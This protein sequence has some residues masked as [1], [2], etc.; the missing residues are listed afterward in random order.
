MS[1]NPFTFGN[2]IMESS[3]FFGR[4]REIRQIVNRLL[5]SAH[6]S[7]SIIGEG[8]MGSTS[9]LLHLHN[10][11][12]AKDLGLTADSF[13]L[14]YVDFQGT[15]L[16]PARFWKRVLHA[17]SRSLANPH[18][19]EMTQQLASRAEIDQFDLEDHFQSLKESDLTTVLLMDEFENI[20]KNPNFPAGFFGGLRALAIHSGLVLI[21]ATRNEL[22]DLYSSEEIKGSPFF[23][24]FANVFLMPLSA[25]EAEEMLDFYLKRGGLS[26][27]SEDKRFIIKMGGGH[28]F[29]LQIAGYHWF[30]ARIEGL[31]GDRLY[32]VAGERIFEQAEPH[33]RDMWA[34]CSN[35]EKTLIK[36]VL[37]EK[38]E[39]KPLEMILASTGTSSTLQRSLLRRGLLTKSDETISFVSPSFE[40]FLRAQI[41][42]DKLPVVDGQLFS[43]Y[44]G[45]Q[46][47]SAPYDC[48][49]SYSTVDQKT[50][51]S[52]VKGLE[53]RGLHCWIAPRD[54]QA[55]TS[56]GQAIISAITE[57]KRMIVV[58]S[59]NANASDQVMQEV[60]RAVSK[61][62]TIIPF[63][64]EDVAPS[65]AMELF[66]SARQWM[67]ALEPPLEAKLDQLADTIKFN[68]QQA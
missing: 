41:I 57:C 8:R 7:T 15:E 47:T 23:N 55:G 51:E 6:E 45:R 46:N 38:S 53:E 67:D 63:R 58:F 29:L 56:Y 14:V 11:D 39:G 22:V 5:S 52:I 18:L 49:I 31:T 12:V 28:P 20:A 27:S 40:Q 3:F 4:K 21:P 61:R 59:S 65:G 43:G 33:F 50:A 42:G 48:F 36:S 26:F 1:Q 32:R 66:L 54:I 35:A 9:L 25:D 34:P 44:P 17:I 13:C 68:K 30:E 10:P 2:P 24:I 37:V 64:I 60:E 62:L 19:A 16:T